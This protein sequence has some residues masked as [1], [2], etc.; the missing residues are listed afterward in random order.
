ML[1]DQIIG[2]Q[3]FDQ[4]FREYSHKWAFKHPVPYDFFRT[5]EDGVGED[6]SWYWRGWFYSTY[7]NDQ[8]LGEV[9]SQ[10][11]KDLMGDDARGKYYWRV[12][13]ENK[14]GILMPVVME[15]TYDDGSKERIKLPVDIWRNNELKF[16]KGFFS[17]KQVVK[18]QLDPDEVFT[19]VDPKNNTWEAP[20]VEQPKPQETPSNGGN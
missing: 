19:D 10:D 18:I 11:T 17:N 20:K 6:L 12:N 7:A 3:L 5:I 15:V 16:Q 1:R 2:P 9:T 14:G 13:I 4:A 8:S